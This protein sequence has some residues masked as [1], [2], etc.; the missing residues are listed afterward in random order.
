MNRRVSNALQLEIKRPA[1][2]IARFGGEEFTCLLPDT[3]KDGAILVAEKLRETIKCLNIENVNSTAAPVLTISIGI[4]VYPDT[5]CSSP[6]ELIE[7]AD[8]NLYLAKKTGR[9]KVYA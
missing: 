9:N 8:K 4:A 1:D 5:A 2:L 3:G 7:A 6:E